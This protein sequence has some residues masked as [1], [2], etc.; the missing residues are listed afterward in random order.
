MAGEEHRDVVVVGGGVAGVNCALE[1]FDI[2]L[3]TILVEASATL[4]GQVT[5]ILHS[6]RNVAAGRFEDGVALQRA[7]LES[8]ET[9]GDRVRLGHAVTSADLG[10]RA[11]EVDDRRLIGRALVVATGTRKQYLDAAPDGA[12]GGDVTY[13]LE[14][15]LPHFAGREVAVIGGGDSGTL[16][17]LALAE[18]GSTVKL[19]H[20]SPALTARHDITRQVHDSPR[21]DDLAGW[22]L[23]AA[24]GAEGLEKIVLVRSSTGERREL[25]VQRLV[26]KIARAPNTQLFDGQLDLD[27]SG[28]VVV[29]RELRTSRPGV[30]AVGDVVS[31]AYPRVAAAL[32]QGSVAARS[33][34]HYLEG[35]S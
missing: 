24:Q 5:E 20:R 2:Q 8:S 35:R 31:G 11:I 9:L 28:A 10:A 7:L 32:G 25:A 6:V 18:R 13:Q 29:D 17:A 15:V 22:E 26:V 3:D 19:I 34:L 21:I 14:P 27:R 4:G 23:E 33:V 16:D 12:F 30:F 1:C